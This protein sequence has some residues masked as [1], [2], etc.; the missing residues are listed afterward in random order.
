MLPKKI[1]DIRA[2]EME[3]KIGREKQEE[4]VD[5]VQ[6]IIEMETGSK[7]SQYSDN[8]PEHDRPFNLAEWIDTEAFPSSQNSMILHWSHFTQDFL[9]ND[10]KMDE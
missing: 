1:L 3:K 4:I 2:N 6:E 7:S 5:D 9:G 8:T 10:K